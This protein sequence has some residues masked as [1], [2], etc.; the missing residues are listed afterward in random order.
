[1]TESKIRKDSDRRSF[2]RNSLAAV[3][4]F[5]AGFSML[6]KEVM[7]A[8]DQV[9][10][11]A[12]KTNAIVVPKGLKYTVKSPNYRVFK[13]ESQR[14]L[15][16]SISPM[17]NQMIG[18]AGM[19]LNRSQIRKLQTAFESR[20]MINVKGGGAASDVSVKVS[21]SLSLNW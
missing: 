9:K 2:L 14:K 7:A 15:V 8:N 11:M 16:T 6:T 19:K 5:T 1:M 18:E 10:K 17:L 21:G 12:V 3:A 13:P 4:G 20:G